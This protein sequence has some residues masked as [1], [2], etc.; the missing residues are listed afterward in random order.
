MFSQSS[1]KVLIAAVLSFATLASSVQASEM[2]HSRHHGNGFGNAAAI[3]AA[4]FLIGAFIGATLHRPDGSSVTSRYPRVGPRNVHIYEE[5]DRHGRVIKRKTIRKG[6]KSQ[7][8]S[9]ETP[10]F[11]KLL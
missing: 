5:T 2:R 11:C 1:K 8:P 6:K 9:Q 10:G 7:S 3:G 4:G